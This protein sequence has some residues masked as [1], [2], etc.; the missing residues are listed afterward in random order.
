[1]LGSVFHTEI[2]CKDIKDAGLKYISQ[3]DT[4][5]IVKMTLCNFHLLK[6]KIA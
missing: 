4:S 6:I 3:K 2:D 5:A 1:M